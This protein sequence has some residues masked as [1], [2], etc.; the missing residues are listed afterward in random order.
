ME[1]KLVPPIEKQEKYWDDW[2][3]KRSINDWSLRRASI[4]LDMIRSLN[5]I[6]PHVIDFGCGNGWFT[7]KL[8]EF[9]QITGIDLSKKNM[10]EAQEKFPL[11]KFIGANLFEYPLPQAYYDVVV[12]QQVIAH[13]SDQKK[14]I[15]L[16][17]GLLKSQGYFILTS[18][19][20]IVMDRLGEEY[21]DHKNA[22]HLENWLTFRELKTFLK[23]QFRIIK[24]L[25][26]IPRGHYGFLK[27][28]NSYKLNKLIGIFLGKDTL[29]TIKEKCGLGYINIIF[30]QKK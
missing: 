21:Q 26:I 23:P 1:E 29:D 7:T 19:N 10:E 6:N 30:A 24:K 17:S 25:S 8:L 12:S 13:V 20:K 2:Q 11:I 4:I 3:E 27:V 15:D 9:G 18:N 16:V 14:Y 28:V 22:G 5:L